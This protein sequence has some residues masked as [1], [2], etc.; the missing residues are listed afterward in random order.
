MGK[1]RSVRQIIEALNNHM[2]L[3][4]N[5]VVPLIKT[6]GQLSEGVILFNP[7]IEEN[8]VKKKFEEKDWFVPNELIE[9]YTI[10]NGAILYK[11]PKYAG[12]TEIL[13][14][15]KVFKIQSECDN[16]PETWYPIAWTDHTIGSIC[17]DSD[18]CKNNE[19]PYIFFLDA[20][21]H[22]EEAIP[23]QGDFLTW[24]SRLIICQGVEYWLWDYYDKLTNNKQ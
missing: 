13:S 3:F 19:F 18:R 2:N 9:F 7:P 14:V 24:L 17:I 12:G 6:D 8:K 23:I 1:E 4:T 22:P 15:E 10:C 11:H 21:N 16:I 5:K 20:I